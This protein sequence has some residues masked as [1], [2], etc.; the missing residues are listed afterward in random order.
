MAGDD[1]TTIGDL[2]PENFV[3]KVADEAGGLKTKE[4]LGWPESADTPSAKV[5][6]LVD[7]WSPRQED[8][9]RL[10][11]DQLKQLLEEVAQEQGE[12]K[13]WIEEELH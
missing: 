5:Q 1:V 4:A 3:E 10:F 8:D 12:V 7:E 9:M 11:T 2:L 6:E 13:Q